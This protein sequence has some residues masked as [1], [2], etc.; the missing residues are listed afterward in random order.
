VTAVLSS[1]LHGLDLV[2]AG[3]SWAGVDRSKAIGADRDVLTWSQADERT[4]AIVSKLATLRAASEVMT[5]LV[6]EV[7]DL[8]EQAWAMRAD[9]SLG[10]AS[11]EAYCADR[12]GD[13]GAI[14]LPAPEQMRVILALTGAEVGESRCSVR[15]AS[16]LMGISDETG[17]RR[18]AAARGV[19]VVRKP[20]LA[21]VAAPV[22]VVAGGVASGRSVTLLVL[23]DLAEAGPAG[24]TIPEAV[25]RLGRSYGSVSGALSALEAQGHV[26]RD[27]EVRGTFR[28]YVLAD[29]LG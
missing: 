4:R 3:P 2:A 19:A 14:R 26:E 23:D 11:F 17:R 10:Y 21:L 8:L 1:G 27:G 15:G 6:D 12:F 29:F 9:V 18:V 22:E 25:V 20:R 24:R 28:P 5:A 16:R 13:L 7:Y